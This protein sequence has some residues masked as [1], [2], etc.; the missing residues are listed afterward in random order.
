[1]IEDIE[2]LKDH[3]ETDSAIFF[4]DSK[5]RDKSIFPTSSEFSISLQQ[6]FKLVTGFDILDAT[7]PTTMYNLESNAIRNS[8]TVVS[9]NSEYREKYDPRAIFK[10][11]QLSTSFSKIFE[12]TSETFVL[13]C[14]ESITAGYILDN[15]FDK[16]T[17][18][19]YF[20]AVRVLYQNI[21]F[22]EVFTPIDTDLL[23]E[24]R[25]FRSTDLN[26]F[27]KKN[28]TVISLYQPEFSDIFIGTIAYYTF[29]STTK[30]IYDRI[31]TK[32]EYELLV[33]NY[34][35]DVEE[36]NYDIST[37]KL[38]LN[39]R[40]NPYGIYCE[41]TSGT[42]K[43]QGKLFFYSDDYIVYNAEKST[44]AS[45]I[46]FSLTPVANNGFYEPMVFGSNINIFGSIYDTTTR[47]YYIKP[48]GLVNMLGERYVI[49][50][51][52]EIEDYLLGSLAY[53]NYTPG[54][55]MFKLSA[56]LDVTNLR[57][58]FVSLVKKPFHPIGKVFKLTFRFETS[59]GVLYDFKGVDVQLLM[60]VKFLVPTQKFKFPKSILNP[61][62]D[63]NFMK[64][65]ME[66]KSI[67]YKEDSDEEEEFD[68][69][70]YYEMY[71]RELEKYDYSTSEDEDTEDS[72]EFFEEKRIY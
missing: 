47:Q 44:M 3:C 70:G 59:S 39:N 27:V 15:E 4:V 63:P 65:M 42:D 10:E 40:W 21:E 33:I 5:S 36:G 69:R 54:V 28:H 9:I 37:I 38:E 52:P 22:T 57:F 19:E 49:L 32:Q 41:A 20:V 31:T 61:N 30:E 1:M 64:Y 68:T 71:K 17:M 46:G 12:E 25:Y 67:Q 55:G 6:P 11:L 43:K 26:F 23:Y 8:F 45:S 50:R 66:S 48:P 35:K 18:S 7:I 62:Y 53:V 56:F 14:D 51:I 34:Y 2:Y 24:N 60:M 13:I 29:F 58:D 72:E 16:V